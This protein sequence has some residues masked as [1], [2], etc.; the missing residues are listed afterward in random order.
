M[1]TYGGAGLVSNGRRIGMMHP[2]ADGYGTDLYYGARRNGAPP[3]PWDGGPLGRDVPWP[4]T[5]SRRAMM[6]GSVEESIRLA[7]MEGEKL[8]GSTGILSP[9]L[10]PAFVMMSCHGG[11]VPF[12]DQTP[13]TLTR[14]GIL[15]MHLQCYPTG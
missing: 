7:M 6:P 12:I 13:T 14:I 4:R 11:L 9:V 10:L 5:E 3:K 8:R 1:M 2:G 15:M